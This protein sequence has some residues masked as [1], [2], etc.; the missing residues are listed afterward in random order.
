MSTKALDE[1]ASSLITSKGG[2]SAFFQYRGFPGQ[3][4]VSVNDEVVHGIGRTDRILEKGDV[5]SL[6]IGV[7]L[8]GFIGDT[9]TTFVLGDAGPEIKRLLD[10]TKKSLDAGIK[11]SIAGNNV[12]HI[13]AAIEKVA[14]SAKLGIVREYVGHGC[15]LKLHEP[16]EIPNFVNKNKGPKLRSGMIL[17]LEPML[18]LG[19]HKV[20][21]ESDR[22]TV[23]T[24]DAKISAHFEHMVLITETEPEILT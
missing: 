17:C 5:V 21:T 18:N 24:S 8:N 3:I 10:N 12:R 11:A 23:R 22:W 13:S 4:C 15:G 14:K 6:D 7:N 20:F 9:A 19:S 1:L 16:P 2:T